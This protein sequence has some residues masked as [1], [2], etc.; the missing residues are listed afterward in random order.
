M[1]EEK[2]KSGNLTPLCVSTHIYERERDTHK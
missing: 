2:Q 1:D